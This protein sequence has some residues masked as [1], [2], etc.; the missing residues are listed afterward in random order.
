MFVLKRFLEACKSSKTGNSP[1]SLQNIAYIVFHVFYFHFFLSSNEVF[2]SE[3]SLCKF[4]KVHDFIVFHTKC[5][6]C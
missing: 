6:T 3:K 2:M 1:L 4:I 5:I